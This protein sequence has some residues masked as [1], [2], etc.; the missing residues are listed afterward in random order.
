MIKVKYQIMKESLL[1]NAE[2]DLSAF[3]TLVVS[4]NT[5]GGLSLTTVNDKIVVNNSILFV[6]KDNKVEENVVKHK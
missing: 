5:F 4:F 3:E 1:E 2:Y 6:D